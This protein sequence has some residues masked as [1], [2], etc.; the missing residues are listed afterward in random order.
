M[1]EDTP[2]IVVTGVAW[3]GG[4]VGSVATTLEDLLTGARK[5]VLALMY[6]LGAGGLE[7]LEALSTT[8]ARGIPVMAVVNRLEQ[9]PLEAQ[10]V[11]HGLLQSCP[12]SGLWDFSPS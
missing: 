11:L 6:S 9:Q 12:W 10:R 8:A 7:T 4:G 2:R 3:M 1:S 5:D